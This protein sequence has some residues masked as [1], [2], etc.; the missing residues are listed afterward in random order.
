[1]L[2]YNNK[3]IWI[4]VFI[5]TLFIIQGYSQD[6]VKYLDRLEPGQFISK[7]ILIKAETLIMVA[8]AQM[9]PKYI[10]INDNIK[11]DICIDSNQIIEYIGTTDTNFHCANELKIGNSLQELSIKHKSKVICETGWGYYVKL[12][13]GW[14]PAFAEGNGMTDK[15]INKKSK[16]KWFFKRRSL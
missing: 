14:Y 9:S 7:S 5:T 11:Y 8:S 2:Y 10:L 3:L 1:M 6:R 13:S 15:P 4:I 12:P 16:I